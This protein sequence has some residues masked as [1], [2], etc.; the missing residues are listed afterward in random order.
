[1]GQELWPGKLILKGI[2]DVED[3]VRAAKTG[4]DAM[5]VSNHGGRQ[6]DGAASSI[7]MLPKIADAVGDD[8]EILFDGGVRTG[9]TCC[10]RSRS[11]RRAA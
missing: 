2:L 5:V 11:A 3:A 10:A 8:I 6:L 1:M 7:S 9:M 4:A